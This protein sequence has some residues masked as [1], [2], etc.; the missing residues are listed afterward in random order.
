MVHSS[1][2]QTLNKKHPNFPEHEF[3]CKCGTGC[4]TGFAQMQPEA[5]ETLYK[6][7]D[8]TGIPMVITSA[9]RCPKHPESIR[10]PNSAHT[11]GHAIDFRVRNSAQ[12]FAFMKV[13]IELGVTRL[14]W[15][16]KL[17]FFHF[18]TD[19]TLPQNVLFPY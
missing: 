1:K 14:G 8:L 5:L 19:T 2:K 17:E 10:R 16:Q 15:N 13:L 6:V 3:A 7:R 18:D 4:G 11:R 12:A 9:Y